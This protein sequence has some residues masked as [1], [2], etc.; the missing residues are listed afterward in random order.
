VPIRIP[1]ASE[2]ARAQATYDA[3]LALPQS[4]Y[5]PAKAGRT[6]LDDPP[7]DLADATGMD[8]LQRYTRSD[9]SLTPERLG[10]HNAIIGK[11]LGDHERAVNPT[12]YI[13]GGGGASGKSTM[14]DQLG[15]PADRVHVDVDI[16]RTML[17]EWKAELDAAAAEGRKA[18][19]MLGSYTHEESSL[20]SKQLID[21]ARDSGYNY[22][23]DGAGDS[24]IGKL[25]QNIRRYTAEGHRIVANYATVDYDQA[26]ARMR[27][28]G[29]SIDA[30]TGRPYGRYIPAAHLRAVHAEVARVVPEAIKHGLFDEFTLW[31]TSNTKP[32]DNG[33]FTAPLKVA[34]AR[35]THLTVHD[36]EAWDRFIALGKGIAPRPGEI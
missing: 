10:L 14:Q 6:M 35:G 9:G 12:A 4:Y 16:I 32:L 19:P 29:D 8:T 3:I 36:H 23:I 25:T 20:I 11:L 22:M 28:R 26:Y 34:S 13:M 18:N 15:L 30:K 7:M 1:P 5:P 24:S 33:K 31:D 17:P 21:A 2:R 27:A